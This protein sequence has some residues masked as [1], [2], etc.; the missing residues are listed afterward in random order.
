RNTRKNT[1]DGQKPVGCE[2]QA[3]DLLWLRPPTVWFEPNFLAP[4]SFFVCF[5]C[6]VVI[7]RHS[8]LATITGRRPAVRAPYRSDRVN[9]GERPLTTKHSKHTKSYNEGPETERLGWEI[10]AIDLREARSARPSPGS[11]P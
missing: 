3:I 8:K 6:F 4:I 10:D 1:T 9:G 7:D 11:P 5:V 2:I